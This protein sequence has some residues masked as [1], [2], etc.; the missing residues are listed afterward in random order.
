MAT[1]T[2]TPEQLQLLIKV[3]QHYLS[4]LQTEIA[5]TDKREYRDELKEQKQALMQIMDLMGG[6]TK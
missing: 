2:F 1:L 6:E 4:E 3:L 5:H